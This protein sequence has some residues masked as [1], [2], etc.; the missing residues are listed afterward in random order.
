MYEVMELT[1]EA[2]SWQDEL[3]VQDTYENYD[4]FRIGDEIMLDV[5]GDIEY[6]TIGD[7][8]HTTK[9]VTLTA[10]IGTTIP[11]WTVCGRKIFAWTVEQNPDEEMGTSGEFE[12]TVN[13]TWWTPTLNRKNIVDTYED[14]HIREIIGR[15]V[16]DFCANDSQLVLETFEAARTQ[17]GVA[18][19]MTDETT[20]RITGLKSQKTWSTGAWTAT[21]TKT[22]WAPIDITDM[23]DI[24]LRHKTKLDSWDN[25]TSMTVRIW[26]DA[27]NYYA[28]TSV[29][30]GNNQ[31]DCWNYESFKID[32]AVQTGTVD[33]ETI[34]RLQISVVTDAN[35]PSDW[36]LF[37]Q[38]LAT[39]WGFTLNNAIRG[40]RKITDYRANYKKASEVIETLTKSL[41]TSWYIDH[42][43]D[44]HVFKQN[45]TPAPI[46]L[47][48]TSQNYWDLS[49]EPDVSMLRNRQT[50][51]GGE[52]PSSV[53][54]DQIQVADGETRSWP[55]D[56]KPKTLSVQV[57][58]GGGYDAKTVWVENLVDE[59]TVDFVYNFQEK[60]L[61]NANHA[62]LLNGYIIKITY[63]PYQPIRVRVSDPASIASMK[64]L[65]W[66][67]GIFDGPIIEDK[68]I[69]S[70]EDARLR[71]QAEINAYSNPIISASFTT[72][73]AG[74]H[75]G[76]VIRITD[77]DRGIDD[78][79]LVQR[80]NRSSYFNWA[81]SS[82]KI[83]CWSTL[84]GLIE[85]FQLLLK[86]S[87]DIT[88]NDSEIIDIVV[89]VD[90]TI[91]I[92]DVITPTQNW[93]TVY[94]ANMLKH[95]R[96]D[97]IGMDWSETS[98]WVIVTSKF[99]KQRYA[100]FSWSAVGEVGFDTWSNHHAW[101]S[102][103]I[104]VA[105][106]GASQY[107]GAR[108]AN[109]LKVKAATAYDISMRIENLVADGL[110]W[111]DGLTVQVKEYATN[112]ATWVLQTTSIIT[113]Q[114]NKQDFDRITDTFTTHAST[115]YIDIIFTVNESTWKISVSDILV[116]EIATESIASAGVV[117]FSEV[118]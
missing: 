9:I 94:A 61:R 90:E 22:L 102:L 37:D 62:T 43:R 86:K 56:Y 108:M 66:W 36:L 42:D 29:M 24:R 70:F 89:N 41:S 101:V 98:E 11:K 95:K 38:M 7:I 30:V 79:F 33:I 105:T 54:Y 45:N 91:S 58:D 21:W 1:I 87:S 23:T 117:E 63:Y 57:D 64:A 92:E 107:I 18:E 76:Q 26:N 59:S 2:T 111:W 5:G 20:D 17:S 67:D 83:E 55:L 14:M 25:I 78:D 73:K 106:G 74:I 53:A 69:S 97:F 51:R 82:Y 4:V 27:S 71:W 100:F 47:T 118:T 104:D 28:W 72:E 40:D 99:D 12:R 68:N 103:Y 15:L 93:K 88:I 50:I 85:F 46:S 96:F 65:L 77:S 34:D 3:K 16:Y 39:S 116:E 10:N 81:E 115:N 44:I 19:A 113:D 60:V 8:D 84:F 49:I 112:L 114:N 31:D 48:D 35:L 109:M 6:A 75:P 110:V 13:V 32:R 80:V 52:A